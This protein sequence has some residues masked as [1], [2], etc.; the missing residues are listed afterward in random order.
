[1]IDMAEVCQ[2][3]QR[4]FSQ[5]GKFT[6]SQLEHFMVSRWGSNDEVYKILRTVVKSSSEYVMSSFDQLP[7]DLRQRLAESPFEL[8][9]LTILDQYSMMGESFTLN[10]VS[11]MEKAAKRLFENAAGE[12]KK[13]A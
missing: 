4:Q 12:I 6:S 13:N 3:L 2:E 8:D 5:P 7:P 9:P 11:K 1:M 10:L